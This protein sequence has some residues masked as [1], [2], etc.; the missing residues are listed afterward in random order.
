MTEKVEEQQWP[1]QLPALISPCSWD[2]Q[3]VEQ[4]VG[5]KS[6]AKPRDRRGRNT[7]M[8]ERVNSD[9]LSLGRLD[10]IDGHVWEM[11]MEGVGKLKHIGRMET[12]GVREA[13]RFRI[14]N[15]SQ[16]QDKGEGKGEGTPRLLFMV[17]IPGLAA[18]GPQAIERYFRFNEIDCVTFLR[19]TLRSVLGVPDIQFKVNKVNPSN[20]KTI[21]F[22]GVTPKPTFGVRHNLQAVLIGSDD[23]RKEF[24]DMWMITYWSEGFLCTLLATMG[25]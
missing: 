24:C 8:R 13:V 1:A 16:N 5:K 22:H 23:Q 21:Y 9:I 3:Q 15:W 2:C 25:S 12:V 4:K 19:S 20:K 7:M 6:R 14:W 11:Q 10:E 18:K 17:N